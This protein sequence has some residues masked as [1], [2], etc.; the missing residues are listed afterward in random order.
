M[1]AKWHALCSFFNFTISQS[2]HG[3][4]T[5]LTLATVVLMTMDEWAAVCCNA[6]VMTLREVFSAWNI[7][8][9]LFKWTLSYFYSLC[10]CFCIMTL[11]LMCFI[12]HSSS[13]PVEGGNVCSLREGARCTR[14][15]IGVHEGQL[16]AQ[17]QK[18]GNHSVREWDEG[19][20]SLH[21]KQW[22]DIMGALSVIDGWS[23]W[24]LLSL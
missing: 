22:L 7:C 3:R 4:V 19:L 23:G 24:G 16:E 15:F 5:A 18:F 10:W 9:F 13:V 12:F 8:F 11:V 21:R 17:C 1:K 2:S 14:G 6:V 20:H